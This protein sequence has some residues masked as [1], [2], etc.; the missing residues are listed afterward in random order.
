[1]NVVNNI[2]ALNHILEDF[3]LKNLK[4]GFVP[5]MGALHQGHA[6][7]ITKALKENEVVVCSIFVNPK[8][9]NDKDDLINYPRTPEADII[10]LENLG[11]QI[12]F[13]PSVE[14]M[15]PFEITGKE[16]P[17]YDLGGLDKIMEGFYR[18]GHFQGVAL[19]V[20]RLFELVR[21]QRAYFGT[22]DYQ[23]V[24]IIRKLTS[25]L[26]LPIEIISCPTLRDSDG[27]AMSS[28]NKNLSPKARK[29]AAHI[30][31]IL[32]L[33]R[34][35]AGLLS[36]NELKHWVE[37]EINKTNFL[38]LDYFELADAQSLTPLQKLNPKGNN[39]GCIAV[40]A[41]KVRLIDNIIL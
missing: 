3:R 41:Q 28:R 23:Q 39:V 15:Y 21:P 37:N 9:F 38:T 22:K 10:L 1:M 26:Q 35:K 25:D 19:V 30:P 13:A 4:I 18:P 24:A 16:K 8:Q 2:T 20:H 5:T 32:N 17:A 33:A 14:E 11:C 40:F 29:M 31:R 12:L 7:L 27:V 34:E 36:V 6:S